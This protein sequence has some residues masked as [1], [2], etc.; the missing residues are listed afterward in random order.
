MLVY[1]GNFTILYSKKQ[2]NVSEG[3]GATGQREIVWPAICAIVG[4]ISRQF[5][6]R[7]KGV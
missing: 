4:K 3:N 2:Y 5:D 7:N 6:T 1:C